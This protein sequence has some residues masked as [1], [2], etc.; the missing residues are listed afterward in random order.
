[1]NYFINWRFKVAFELQ[2]IKKNSYLICLTHIKQRFS[3]GHF[4]R[5]WVWL[6]FVWAICT[7]VDSILLD[8]RQCCILHDETQNKLFINFMNI[9]LK[10]FIYFQDLFTKWL[11]WSLIAKALINRVKAWASRISPAETIKL[12]I[13]RQR[14]LWRIID[15]ITSRYLF[16]RSFDLEK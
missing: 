13:A 5:L 10:I 1:M 11:Q 6:K 9:Q 2:L 4:Y 3:F 12:N 14:P 16:H 15:L 8:T 7:Y